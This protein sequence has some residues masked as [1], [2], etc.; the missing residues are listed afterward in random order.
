MIG[1]FEVR[2]GIGFKR[3]IDLFQIKEIQK[4]KE[5]KIQIEHLISLNTRDKNVGSVV[6]DEIEISENNI[7]LFD[8]GKLIFWLEENKKLVKVRLFPSELAY[9]AALKRSFP[10]IKWHFD[11]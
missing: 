8:C 10:T 1:W 6:G 11:Q 4:D 5:R 3:K 9:Q 7:K 2:S